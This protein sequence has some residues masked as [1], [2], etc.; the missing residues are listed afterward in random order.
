MVLNLRGETIELL[1]EKAFYW[2]ERSMLVL[3]DL[4]LGK[5][6]SLQAMGIPIPSISHQ[7][8]FTRLKKM[9]HQHKP[10]QVV[11][12]GDLIHDRNSWSESLKTQLSLFFKE[13]SL[14][15]FTL[16][17]GNHERRSGEILKDWPLELIVGEWKVG[18]FILA[19]GHK[20]VSLK[21]DEFEIAGHVHPVIKI[22]QGP[23]KLRLPC[24]VLAEQTLLIPSFGILTGGY[25]IERK[26]TEKI[27]AV[28][29]NTIIPIS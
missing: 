20:E 14:L 6:D 3:S 19:H 16:V 22:S 9:I 1:P 24:F 2:H 8:D 27:Y 7:D 26:K 25:E 13:F 28:A 21:P 10:E 11:F 15:K 29:E 18:P 23:I 4:H 12:L 5:A 17:L